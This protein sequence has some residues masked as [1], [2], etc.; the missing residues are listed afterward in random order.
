MKTLRVASLLTGMTALLV[1]GAAMAGVNVGI[2]VGVPA[3]VYVAPAPVYA[4]PPP[5]PVVYQPAPV[6]APAYAPAP[7]IVIGWHGDRYW[8]GRRY[9]ARDDWYRRHGGRPGWDRD[10]GHGHWDNGRHNGWH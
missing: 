2:N 7:T 5:P 6:Y 4:P 10:R 8:D 1:S 9:W 3:P